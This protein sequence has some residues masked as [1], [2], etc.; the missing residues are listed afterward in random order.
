MSQTMLATGYLPTF[1]LPW[2]AFFQPAL[3]RGGAQMMSFDKFLGVL[4]L[5]ERK[6]EKVDCPHVSVLQYFLEANNGTS[7]EDHKSI[8][9]P[10]ICDRDQMAIGQKTIMLQLFWRLRCLLE[11]IHVNHFPELCVR[12]VRDLWYSAA[13]LHL[14]WRGAN[15]RGSALGQIGVAKPNLF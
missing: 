1:P 8:R 7:Q 5:F 3:G 2:G 4:F 15:R 6:V 10:D 12:P 13:P 11:E 14:A 9:E